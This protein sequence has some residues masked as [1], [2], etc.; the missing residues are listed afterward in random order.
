MNN[1]LIYDIGM[2]NGDDTAY[3]LFKGYNVVAIDASPDLVTKANQR[4]KDAIK[5]GR[6][7][8]LN[9]GIDSKEGNMNFYLNKVNSVWNSFDKEIGERGGGGYDVI[10]VKTNSL[11]QVMKL[12]G[13]PYYM[14]IDI[15]GNDILCL[16]SLA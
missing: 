13:V 5:E 7:K 6:V 11:E 1:Q 15:E 3:Y 9:I 2:H 10:N 8:I 4:F 16:V 14:K 12:H